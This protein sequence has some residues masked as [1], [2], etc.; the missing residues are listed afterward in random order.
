[1][2][3]VTRTPPKNIT[4]KTALLDTSTSG[5]NELI[6]APTGGG[7]IRV[8]SLVVV[9]GAAN[10]VK[11]MSASTAI[12]ALSALAANGGLVLPFSEHGWCQCAANEALNIN[13][14]AATAVGVT[15]Q[16]I[17]L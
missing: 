16:Y 3:N 13:L 15:V 1:M 10:T 2:T 9:A 11:L 12:T 7:A 5:S 4:V 14:S 17:V 6:A 8:L